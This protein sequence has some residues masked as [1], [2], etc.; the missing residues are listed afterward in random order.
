MLRSRLGS[1]EGREALRLVGLWT[2]P[3]DVDAFEHDYLGSHLPQLD[4]LAGVQT[5]KTS[6]C[7][8]GPYFRITE[9]TF[10]ALDDI[11]AA[12]GAPIGKTILEQAHALAT[13]FGNRLEVLVVADSG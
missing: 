6:R 12:L 7:I 13:K 2:E 1:R 10:H 8:H 5:I 11:D 9:L 3:E 4:S